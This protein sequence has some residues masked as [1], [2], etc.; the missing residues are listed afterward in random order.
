MS[1]HLPKGISRITSTIQRRC[2]DSSF[3]LA[4]HRQLQHQNRGNHRQI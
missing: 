3:A 2:N 1:A 4:L